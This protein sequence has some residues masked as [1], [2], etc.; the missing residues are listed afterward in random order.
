[1]SRPLRIGL[2]GVGGFG[3]LHRNA[4]AKLEAEG[5]ARLVAAV[6]PA[7]RNDLELRQS[8][9]AQRI[10]TYSDCQELLAQADNLDG[11]IVATPI[12]YHYEMTLACLRRGIPTYLEKPPVPFVEQLAGLI[13]EDPLQRVTVGF[14]QIGAAWMQDLKE[15]ISEGRLGKIRSIRAAASWPRLDT[16]Y[17][18][19][20]WAGKMHLHGQ[21]VFDGPATNALA[22]LV[23]NIMYLAGDDRHTFDAPVRVRGEL[24]RA[25][26]I[27]SYDTAC[28]QGEFA[29]G[30]VFAAAFTHA[31]EQ[32]MPFELHVEGTHGWARV[33]RDGGRME[34]SLGVAKDYSEDIDTLLL[35]AHRCFIGC[36]DG[37]SQ[38]GITRLSDAMGYVLATHGMLK[39][40]KIVHSIPP[41]HIRRYTREG[42]AGYDVPGLLEAL[43]ETLS[44]GH[45]FSET[46]CPWAV[47]TAQVELGSEFGWLPSLAISTSP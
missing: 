46:G 38:P 17:S 25:R 37:V 26:P 35:N 9:A 23:H 39:S 41:A 31:A 20:P 16:Y 19:A 6:D 33:T 28:L 15:W 21:P 10:T 44:H 34:S 8:F 5:L 13:R 22:H 4:I 18:R 47:R 36:Q 40:S 2:V 29:S 14:Q 12:P 1:M 43:R 42:D 32:P 3:V 24:Y 45:L 30:T 7:F 11:V 27:E